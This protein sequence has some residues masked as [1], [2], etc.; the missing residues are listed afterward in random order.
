MF[1]PY[2]NLPLTNTPDRFL[3]KSTSPKPSYCRR[4]L[5]ETA[6]NFPLIRNRQENRGKIGLENVKVTKTT[7][8]GFLGE[9]GR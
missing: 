7:S 1:L 9:I 4:S 2:K 6:Y 8:N 5:L 3:L